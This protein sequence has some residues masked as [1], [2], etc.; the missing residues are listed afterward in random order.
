MHKTRTSLLVLLI[1]A[2]AVF[3][4]GCTPQT[5]GASSPTTT[6][7]S[8][9]VAATPSPSQST[10]PPIPASA[11][12]CSSPTPSAAAPSEAEM[13]KFKDVITSG[14]SQAM[15]ANSCDTVTL[16]L[17]GSSCCGPLERDSALSQWA[18]RLDPATAN[19]SFDIDPAVVAEWR[20]HFYG[21]YVPEGSLIAVDTAHNLVTS[22]IF[23]GNIVTALFIAN[24]EQMT[25]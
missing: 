6:T 1:A 21:Q 22:V 8:S 16:I 2:T 9:S 7:A 12:P 5:E 17:A 18:Q 10:A 20:N 19:W 24:T 4:T 14:N 3:V 15:A 13:Q 11:F 25:Q 23:D